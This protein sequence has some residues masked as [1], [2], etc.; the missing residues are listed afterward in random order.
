MQWLKPA[1]NARVPTPMREPVAADGHTARA[2]AAT[3][4][5]R[6]Y[7]ATCTRMRRMHERGAGRALAQL[8]DMHALPAQWQ[9]L[10]L[11]LL[12]LLCLLVRRRRRRSRMA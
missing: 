3:G 8:H 6:G 2:A 12:L 5:V 7:T 10:L 1:T 11:L 4:V 9:R